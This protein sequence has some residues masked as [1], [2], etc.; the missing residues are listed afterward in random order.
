MTAV[1]FVEGLLLLLAVV[2]VL[3]FLGEV[4]RRK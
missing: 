4:F 3:S 2:T 1:Q